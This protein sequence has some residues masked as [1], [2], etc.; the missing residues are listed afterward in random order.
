VCVYTSIDKNINKKEFIEL[1]GD[2]MEGRRFGK[3][4]RNKG[5]GK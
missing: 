3:A 1:R 2:D 4:G 5:R